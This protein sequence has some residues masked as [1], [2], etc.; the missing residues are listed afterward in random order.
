MLST[1]A[2]LTLVITASA[3]ITTSNFAGRIADAQGPVAGAA[4]IAVHTPWRYNRHAVRLVKN[5]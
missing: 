1:M 2:A 4:V 3:Q 5:E